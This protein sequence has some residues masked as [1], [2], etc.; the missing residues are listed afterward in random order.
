M[1]EESL[2]VQVKEPYSSFHCA[3]P[4]CTMYACSLSSRDL[5]DRD[6]NWNPP[7]KGESPPVQVIQLYSSLHDY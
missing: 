1:Q 7:V 4:V 3:K 5:S 6:S 2:H